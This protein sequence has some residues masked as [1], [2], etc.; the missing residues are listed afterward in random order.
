MFSYEFTKEYNLPKLNAEILATNLPISSIDWNSPTQFTVNSTNQLN[1]L[2]QLALNAV[3]EAH[4]GGV[5]VLTLVTNKIVDARTF[6]TRLIDKYAAQNVLAGYD[7]EIIIQIMDRCDKVMRA[8][9]TGSL[10]VAIHEINLVTPD[11]SIITVAKLAAIRNEIQ[12][13][14]KIPRT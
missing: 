11:D 4:N 14:L 10:Y 2:Q 13:Y 7:V 8:L 9:K 1:N 5:D 3:I 6:G 12:D